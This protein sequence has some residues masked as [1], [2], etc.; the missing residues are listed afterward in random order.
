MN[1]GLVALYRISGILVSLFAYIALFICVWALFSG[2][3]GPFLIVTF[4]AACLVIYSVLSAMFGRMV[5]MMQ[6][7]IR[8][9]LKD[10]IKINDYISLVVSALVFLGTLPYIGNPGA[11]K[12]AIDTVVKQH[13]ELMRNYET[14]I[15]PTQLMAVF[16]GAF[17]LSLLITA[18]CIWTLKLV[19]KYRGFFK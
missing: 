15:T 4:L 5:L 7:P 19:K 16:R 11:I 13:P 3:P 18:H 12:A 6:Q 17:F 9:T 14:S 10:W 2:A 1:K 8:A